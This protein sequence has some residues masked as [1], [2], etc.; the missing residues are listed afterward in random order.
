MDIEKLRSFITVARLG[1]F[2]AAADELYLTASAV[3]KHVAA[4]EGELG[5][6]LLMRKP[7]S[8]A[9]TPEGRACLAHAER[10]VNEY[11][12]MTASLVGGGLSVV[13]IPMHTSVT[14]FVRRFAEQ[15]P[16]ITVTLTERHGPEVVKAV[17][18]GEFELG[19][20]GTP[21]SDSSRLERIIF[22]R[23]RVGAVLPAHHP[24]AQRGERISVRELRDERFIFMAPETGMY[25][26]YVN[27]CRENGFTPKTAGVSSR[28]DMIVSLI[29]DGGG[30]SFLLAGEITPYNFGRVAFLE[31]KEEY[32]VGMALLFRKNCTLSRPAALFKSLFDAAHI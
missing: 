31:L 7:K 15:C 16:S 19:F 30:A 1:S 3:S 25:D 28:E 2:S 29:C 9:L 26:Y 24:L 8:V 14:P 12:E 4:L 32:S 20:A 21:Y 27:I 11:N 17:E 23:R 18:S 5:C 6:A 13:T 10:I 22:D